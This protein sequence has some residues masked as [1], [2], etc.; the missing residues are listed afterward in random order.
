MITQNFNEIYKKNKLFTTKILVVAFVVLT[1]SHLIFSLS[2]IRFFYV[3]AQVM[4]LASYA[5]LLAVIIR[6]TK[7]QNA[8][9]GKSK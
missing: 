1:A 7:K 3:A 9:S 4:Q 8:K 5:I 6:I 2:Q